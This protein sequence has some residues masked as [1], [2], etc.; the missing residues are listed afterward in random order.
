MVP[1]LEHLF[2][3]GNNL[4]IGIVMVILFLL[5]FF[6]RFCNQL[7]ERAFGPIMFLWFTMLL[8]VG[9]SQVVQ[10]LSLIHI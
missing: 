10:H 1:G 4:V 8:V 2:E 6:Q 7:I 9:F 5:F 3:A